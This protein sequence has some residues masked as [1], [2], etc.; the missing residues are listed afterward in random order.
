MRNDGRNAVWDVCGLECVLW[1]VM[2]MV[3]CEVKWNVG[4][5]LNGVSRCGGVNYG[6]MCN[7]VRLMWNVAISDM[8]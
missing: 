2:C 1:D 5:I 8:L 6:A 4:V 7:V 3:W